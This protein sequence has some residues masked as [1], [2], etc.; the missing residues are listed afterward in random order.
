MIIPT[1]DEVII[2]HEKLI[3]KTGGLNGIRDMGML[4]SAVMIR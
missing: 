3:A 1:T 4:E 2:M